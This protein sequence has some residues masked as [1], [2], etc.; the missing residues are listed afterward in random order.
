MLLFFKVLEISRSKLQLRIH[1]D[2][3]VVVVRP[4]SSLSGP[5]TSLSDLFD[6]SGRGSS[7]VIG[8]EKEDL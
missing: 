8:G 6:S 1:Y 2:K 4:R 3:R 5:G 7:R